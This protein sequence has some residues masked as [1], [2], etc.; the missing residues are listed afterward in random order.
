MNTQA[1]IVYVRWRRRTPWPTMAVSSAARLKHGEKAHPTYTDKGTHNH[2]HTFKICNPCKHS[3]SESPP[4]TCFS[5]SFLLTLR[6]N[7]VL[8]ALSLSDEE[9]S[10]HMM[11]SGNHTPPFYTKYVEHVQKVIAHNAKLEFECI[12]REHESRCAFVS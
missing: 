5:S 3:Q 1:P 11:V 6:V 10:A 8:A 2:M 4:R 9:F 7:Q 12:W